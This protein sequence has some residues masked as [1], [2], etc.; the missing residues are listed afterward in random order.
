MH[1]GF[2]LNFCFSQQTYRKCRVLLA[3]MFFLSPSVQAGWFG[4]NCPDAIDS[5]KPEWVKQGFNAHQSGFRIGFGEARYHKKSSYQSLLDEAENRA[6]EDIANSVQVEVTSVTDIATRLDETTQS[7][8]Y[9]QQ[10]HSTLKSRSHVD[11]PGLPIANKWQDA[12][13]CT[14]Y[15]QVRIAELLLQKV[16]KKTQ[17]ESYN[18]EAGDTA[19]P[20]KSR[21]LSI[22][23][24]I[25]ITKRHK[26][27]E[28]QGSKTSAQLLSQY[29]QR[30]NELKEIAK[31]NNHAIFVINQTSDQNTHALHP[32][33]QAL[34]LS[35]PGS[36]E[37]NK[38]CTTSSTCL[39][40]ANDTPANYASIAKVEMNL[41]KQNGF[42]LG[43]FTVELSRWDLSNNHLE[44]TSGK[45]MVPVMNRHKHSLTLEKAMTKWLKANG[46]KL[47]VFITNA[48]K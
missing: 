30:F 40:L 27:G 25:A 16:L 12:D 7:S 19:K 1:L 48:H 20:I 8:Q 29:Q 23:E 13:S 45:L 41:V 31:R 32:L 37:V 33:K 17:A 38:P 18:K 44:E 4:N 3:L 10:T 43:Q 2:K 6:R 14:V 36:F 42:W 5:A 22:R 11:L 26:F 46:Q 39:R 28:I 35:L 15:V 34:K 21:V 9:S 47:T 24:A